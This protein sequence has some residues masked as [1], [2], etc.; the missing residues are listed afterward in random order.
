MIALASDGLVEAHDHFGEDELCRLLADHRHEPL[1][2]VIETV[3][4]TITSQ[5]SRREDDLTL[6]LIR[7]E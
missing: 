7:R 3:L 6:V 4:G 1:D 5:P 2:S